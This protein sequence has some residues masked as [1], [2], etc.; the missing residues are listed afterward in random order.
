MADWKEIA[1]A[2]VARRSL[3]AGAPRSTWQVAEDVLV[4]PAMRARLRAYAEARFGI[5][6]ADAD[7]LL[8]ETALELLHHESYVRKPEGYVFAVFRSRCVRFTAD[9]ARW[10]RLELAPKNEFAVAPRVESNLALRQALTELSIRCK[11]LLCAY[12][13]EGRSFA[14]AATKFALAYKTYHKALER[15]LK[16]LR[17]TL[18]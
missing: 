11:Q 5:S 3:N 9:R 13:I 15:C 16:R 8:Q 12:Y 7:D 1:Y 17:K 14:E 10:R 2:D 18:A 4:D 6:S